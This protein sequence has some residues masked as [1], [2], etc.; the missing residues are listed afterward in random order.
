M[1]KIILSIIAFFLILPLP[2]FS[3]AALINRKTIYARGP[4]KA[5]YGF[6]R[7]CLSASISLAITVVTRPFPFKNI[8]TGSKQENKNTP[9]LL[10]HGLYHSDAAWIYLSPKL[11]KA[12]FP[13]LH[14]MAYNSFTTSY[15]EL[16]SKAR[17]QIESIYTESGCRKVT[18]IGHS[19]GGLIG[20]GAVTDPETASRCCR[21]ISLGTP[22]RGSL[23]AGAAIGH[24]GRSLHPKSALFSSQDSY[25]IPSGFPKTAIYSPVDEMV[26][27]W[28]NLLPREEDNLNSGWEIIPSKPLGHVAMLFSRDV[29]G[30]IIAQLVKDKKCS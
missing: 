17:K 23:L 27:P 16:V 29:A 3:F 30:I 9:L 22:Y 15:P 7:G 1:I 25:R 28:G 2:L 14:T 20:A 4:A 12:G 5:F 8:L 19:L 10:I 24:L 11:R 26:Q 6:F 18:I 13:N 21:F